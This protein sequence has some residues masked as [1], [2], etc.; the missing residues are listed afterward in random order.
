M[1]EILFGMTKSGRAQASLEDLCTL[2]QTYLNPNLRAPRRVNEPVPPS[3]A[4]SKLPPP[5]AEVDERPKW[6]YR[7]FR[8][9]KDA[10]VPLRKAVVD[11]TKRG[12]LCMLVLL[13]G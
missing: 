8:L 1:E 4:A 12:R 11:P 2:A 10:V 9:W 7:R 13:L 5:C 6:R 3:I